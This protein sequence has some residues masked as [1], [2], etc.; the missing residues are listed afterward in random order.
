MSTKRFL[1]V[2]TLLA[3]ALVLMLSATSTPGASALNGAPRQSIDPQAAPANPGSTDM[4]MQGTMWQPQDRKSLSLFQPLGWGT[5]IRL[6]PKK[7]VDQWIQIGVPLITYLESTPQKVKYVEF[8]ARSSN[9]AST[10][11]VQMDLWDNDKSFGSFSIAWPADNDYHCFGH[12]FGA[13]AA[14]RSTLGISVKL[15]FA[16]TTDIITLYKAWVR[17]TD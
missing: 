13:A 3:L 17:T 4:A 14:W 9:G 11:P 2:V 16:N 8:C 12:D 10:K 7:P 15:H 6:K 5:A 1:G